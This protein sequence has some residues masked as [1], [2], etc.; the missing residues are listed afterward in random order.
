MSDFKIG[1][2]VMLKCYKWEGQFGSVVGIRPSSCWPV[3]VELENGH[4]RRLYSI[5]E[6][7]VVEEEADG[8][9]D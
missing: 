6:V 9:Q 4:G 2:R 7:E 1:D 3:L 5:R 8:D